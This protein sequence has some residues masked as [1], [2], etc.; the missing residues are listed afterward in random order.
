MDNVSLIFLPLFINR[1]TELAKRQID[2]RLKMSEED[3]GFVVLLISL[4]LG[5]LG[6]VFVFPAT[7]LIA[8]Q[9]ASLLAE[10]VVTG[11]V[12][13]GLANGIN[14]LGNQ[15]SGVL[16]KPATV[17]AVKSESVTVTTPSDDNGQ[18]SIDI[19]A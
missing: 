14:F 12:I 3:S 6:V 7:N 4:V 19:A 11:V 17:S 18:V 1:I 16:E 8:G 2:A 5:V 10:Q 9:G 15:F 13:G